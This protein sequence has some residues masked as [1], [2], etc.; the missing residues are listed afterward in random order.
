[1]LASQL[2]YESCMALPQQLA[3]QQ[4][5]Q[6]ALSL[7]LQQPQQLAFVWAASKSASI[8]A[9]QLAHIAAASTQQL[10]HIAAAPVFLSTA[11][12]LAYIAN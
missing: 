6:L 8:A 10:A 12:R 4:L 3:S 11:Q 1:M 9:H 7:L 5:L 2:G